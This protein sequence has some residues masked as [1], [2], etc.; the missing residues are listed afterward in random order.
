[1]RKIICLRKSEVSVERISSC[2]VIGNFSEHGM[3]TQ[4]AMFLYQY[5]HGYV[6]VTTTTSY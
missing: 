6:I 4:S 2:N 5:R 1:M 3:S